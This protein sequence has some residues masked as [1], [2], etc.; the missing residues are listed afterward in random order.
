MLVSYLHIFE[1]HRLGLNQAWP[2]KIF[3]FGSHFY[4]R[5]PIPIKR[6][7]RLSTLM[8]RSSFVPVEVLMLFAFRCCLT[9]HRHSLPRIFQ[10]HRRIGERNPVLLFF[11]VLHM[12]ETSLS[13]PMEIKAFFSVAIVHEVIK[14]G[15]LFSYNI[16][17]IQ[18][19]TPWNPTATTHLAFSFFVLLSSRL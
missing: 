7:I 14:V 18:S 1:L 4:H 2:P 9:N 12:H 3:I 15:S 6:T 16:N 11:V 8:S 5:D 10:S 19:P 17:Q 13:M